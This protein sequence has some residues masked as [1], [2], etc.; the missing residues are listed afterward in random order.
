MLLLLLNLLSPLMLQF[1]APFAAAV[2]WPIQAGT[3][4]LAITVVELVIKLLLHQL[5]THI[6]GTRCA[7]HACAFL[8]RLCC[9]AGGPCGN[10]YVAV[11]LVLVLLWC[12][13]LD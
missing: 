4:P 12:M 10:D 1:E 8:H 2:L 11:Q 3:V 5:Q 7:V 6:A 13:L 9:C